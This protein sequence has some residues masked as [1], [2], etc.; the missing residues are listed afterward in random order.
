[1]I[2]ISTYYACYILLTVMLMVLAY[3]RTVS[4][5]DYILTGSNEEI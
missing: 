5:V 1:M 4:E 2:D 3:A